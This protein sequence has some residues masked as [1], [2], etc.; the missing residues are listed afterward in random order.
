MRH[1]HFSHFFQAYGYEYLFTLKYV[2]FF[3][4]FLFSIHLF[5]YL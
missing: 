3:S 1:T 4:F 5:F 2:Q